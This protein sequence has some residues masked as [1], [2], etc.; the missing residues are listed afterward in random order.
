MCRRTKY[1]REYRACGHTLPIDV[2]DQYAHHL[3]M[4]LAYLT[5]PVRFKLEEMEELD[6]EDEICRFCMEGKDIDGGYRYG[7][8]WE[9]SEKFD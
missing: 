8:K 4:C 1:Y 6:S 5:E 7:K 3:G 9:D 2:C